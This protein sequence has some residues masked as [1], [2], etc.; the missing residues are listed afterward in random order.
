MN[1]VLSG[2]MWNDRKQENLGRE[3]SLE[4]LAGLEGLNLLHEPIYVFQAA[5]DRCEP[6]VRDVVNLA[7]ALDYPVADLPAGDRFYPGVEDRP[8]DIL[9]DRLEDHPVQRT[10]L[11]R[12]QDSYEDFAPVKRLAAAVPLDNIDDRPFSPLE[13]GKT[14]VATGALAPSPNASPAFDC[15]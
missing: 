3:L 11:A 5:I 9:G 15:T 14:A 12:L 2:S 7:Q 10:S 4:L 13:R 8:L 1:L 6:D